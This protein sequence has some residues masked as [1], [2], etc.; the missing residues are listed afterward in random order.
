MKIETDFPLKN[1]NTFQIEASAARY[2]RFDTQG[3][4]AHY[5]AGR[6]LD[7]NRH[8]VLGMG[9]NLLFA[10]DFDGTILHPVLTGIE[11]LEKTDEHVL[12]RAK[13]GENWD[14]LVAFAVAQG[15]GGIENLS[16]IPGSVGASVVQNIGA[17]GIEVRDSVARIETI[18]ISNGHKTTI[19]PKDCGFDYRYSHFK[20]KW[21]GRYI[22]TAVVFKLL[23][24]P[25][26]MTEY[27]GVKA[28][29][30][31]IG[32]LTLKTLRAAII[33]LR[34]SRLPDPAV[35][36][37]AGSFFKNPIV[38]AS[39]LKH[40]LRK[41]S[42]MPH[43]PQGNNHHKLAA[44]WLIDQCGWKGKKVGRAAVHERQALVLVN[45]GGASGREIFDLSEKIR[46]SVFSRFAIQ[47]DREVIV[48]GLR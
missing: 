32:S 39:V 16:L 2:V 7:K 14:D 13:A 1:L 21:N 25:V 41:F 46:R 27:P 31:D 48:V 22:I 3:E 38:D 8:L 36:G 12:V 5:L 37:N 4:I 40:M 45:T 9:S 6:S 11:V 15:L 24:K 19:S 29:L 10:A 26:F 34:Q 28:A 44:G 30:A 43:Y 17:Y 20:G 33:A 47:L 18:K 42:D 35:L 23:R